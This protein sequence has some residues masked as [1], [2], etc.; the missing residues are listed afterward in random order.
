MKQRDGKR[1]EVH[2]HWRGGYGFV[3]CKT[4]VVVLELK[5]GLC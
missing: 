2:S 3:I 1:N 5:R 4:E